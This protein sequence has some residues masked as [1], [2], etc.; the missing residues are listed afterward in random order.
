M[1]NMSA[2]DLDLLAEYLD[3]DQ[4]E[5]GLDFAATHGFLSAIAVGPLF[6]QW[7][8]ELFDQKQQSVPKNI[9]EQVKLWLDDIRQNLANEEGIDFPFEVEEADVDSSLGDWSVGFVDA[10]FLNEEAWFAPEFE[11]QL[12]DLTLPMMVFS[13]I[14]EE[15][16]QMESFRR[17]GQLMDEIAEEIPNNLNELYLMYHTPNA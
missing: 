7:L 5:H 9:I 3:G 16:P 2:L 6:K 1:E 13:G 15:D 10:M 17:N 4:N 8:E 11:E 12:I 14:D